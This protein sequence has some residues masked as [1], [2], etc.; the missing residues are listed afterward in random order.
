M[1]AVS[2]ATCD[3][4]LRA[5]APAEFHAAW[6]WS[7]PAA[8]TM[9]GAIAFGVT[10][11]PERARHI[12]VS[13]LSVTFLLVHALVY[14]YEAVLGRF[15]HPSQMVYLSELGPAWSSVEGASP[16]PIFVGALF[17]GISLSF[18]WRTVSK[19]KVDPRAERWLPK[20][21]LAAFAFTAFVTA[22]GLFSGQRYW[23]TQVPLV[24]TVASV[25]GDPSATELREADV[26]RVYEGLAVEPP[27]V[28]DLEAPLCREVQAKVPN[29]RSVI[30]VLVESLGRESLADFEGRP[31]VPN[32]LRAAADGI[33][34][35]RV[36]ASGTGSDQA[37]PALFAGLPGITRRPLVFRPLPTFDGLPEELA[38]AGYAT[39]YMHGGDLSFVA[40]RDFLRDVGF[41][42]IVELDTT[43]RDL[44]GWGVDDARMY[45]RFREALAELAA[46]PAPYF[47][48]F[49]TLSAHHPYAFPPGLEPEFGDETDGERF[50]SLNHYSDDHF[51]RFY[52]WYRANE[53]ERGTLLVVV[54]DHVSQ[55]LNVEASRRGDPQMYEVPL[56]LVGKGLRAPEGARERLAAQMDVPATIRD[57]LGMNRGRCEMG[58]SVLSNDFPTDRIL[59]GGDVLDWRMH[60]LRTP[61]GFYVRQLQRGA[62]L[63]QPEPND[64]APRVRLFAESMVAL[65]E[66]L[67]A[68]DGFAPRADQPPAREAL[69]PIDEPITYRAW[70]A[71]E[72]GNGRTFLT[73]ALSADDRLVG[74]QTA[75]EREAFDER[76][77][78]KTAAELGLPEVEA[79]LRG[80][81]DLMIAARSTN[82]WDHDGRLAR[83]L[84]AA[85]LDRRGVHVHSVSPD[86]VT[87]L[88][89]YCEQCQVGWRLTWVPERT[90]VAAAL[91]LGVDYVVIDAAQADEGTVGTF[92][93]AGIR[94]FVRGESDVP[95]DGTI[96]TP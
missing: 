74:L 61:R 82:L 27:D 92:R 77:V 24:W 40:Q 11:L 57:V 25:F 68:R 31:V 10:Y 72:Q 79:V 42:R 44:V 17:A 18:F 28:V 90:A 43:D 55:A 81:G 22:G 5:F 60:T 46:D 45:V 53:Y 6:L 15:P 75:A 88:R 85:I 30:F 32:V 26:R 67:L 4:A 66:W 71:G 47:A 3:V 12:V 76:A 38:A 21:L 1:W 86:V 96:E 50:R 49:A 51:G 95:V 63:A 2:F 69:A 8:L 41:E 91:G 87:S 59:G 35:E 20:V 34:V 56:I 19:A 39:L 29:G 52:D 13:V 84:G 78:R 93:S 16:V 33:L 36:M 80:E 48:T 9:G 62:F 54:G 65:T 94:V 73:V 7:I 83:R 89:N 58:H 14:R 64:D 70:K 23:A 37:L